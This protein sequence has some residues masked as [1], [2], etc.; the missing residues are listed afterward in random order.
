MIGRKGTKKME[1]GQ[2]EG[3][4]RLYIRKGGEGERNERK[5]K[6]LSREKRKRGRKR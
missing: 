4:G 6:G 2:K 1:G 3:D 5:E